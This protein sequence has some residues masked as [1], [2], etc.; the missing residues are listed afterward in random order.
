LRAILHWFSYLFHAVLALF[1]AGISLVG[2]ISASNNFEIGAIPW[3]K[4]TTL[5]WIVLA[6]S[7]AGCASI[8]L[9]IRKRARLLF[10][11]WAVTAFVLIA[12]GFLFSD[13]RYD[14]L[15]H[16]K[17]VAW[18]I[19]GALVAALGAISRLASK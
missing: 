13:Y 6:A 9:A 19:A 8:I 11:L 18:W 4:G 14:D 10:A 16:F 1:L 12:R 3:W 17:S 2:L 5:T 7:I 15:A